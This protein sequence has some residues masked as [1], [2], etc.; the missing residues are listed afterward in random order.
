MELSDVDDYNKIMP[1]LNQQN[2]DKGSNYNMMRTTDNMR[3]TS[4]CLMH[5]DKLEFVVYVV[6]GECKFVGVMDKTPKDYEPVITIRV[7][8]YSS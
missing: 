6:P 1:A 2:F 4:Q 8:E 7:V 3:S 5:L